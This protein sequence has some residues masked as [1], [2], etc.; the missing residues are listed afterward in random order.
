[1]ATIHDVARITGFSLGTVSNVINRPERVAPKTRAKI[2]RVMAELNYTPNAMA[3]GLSLGQSRNVGVVLPNSHHPYFAHIVDGI[4]DAAFPTGYRVTLL[5]TNYDEGFERQYLREFQQKMYAGMIFVSRQLPLADLVNYVRYG[6][7]VTCENV[8][9]M[10]ITSVYSDRTT[11]YR[12]AFR[13]VW[14]RGYRNV[15]LLGL[16]G[17]EH[18]E[19]TRDLMRAYEYVFHEELD[20][21]RFRPG[22]SSR[23]DGYAAAQYLATTDPKID[24]VMAN[25]DDIA[26]GVYAAYKELGVKMPGIMGTENQLSSQLLHLPTI[27]HHLETLGHI[28][29]NQAIRPGIRHQLVKSDFVAR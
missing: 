2:E 16:R 22:V 11:T 9:D 28:A 19:T 26:A 10:K 4:T 3:R 25:G 29:F 5:P 15:A 7:I 23:Q 1:M 13:W 17:P 6:Q 21:D 14:Q 27:N 20:P 18:S 24:F 8:G 12:A